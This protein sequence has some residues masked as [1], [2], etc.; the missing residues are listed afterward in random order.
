MDGED[1]EGESVSLVSLSSVL[2]IEPACHPVASTTM[3]VNLPTGVKKFTIEDVY[4]Y[5]EYP[6][7]DNRWRE[8]AFLFRDGSILWESMAFST[9]AA[10]GSQFVVDGLIHPTGALHLPGRVNGEYPRGID[11]FVEELKKRAEVVH[12]YTANPWG[13]SIS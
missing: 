13:I 8:R 6:G 1:R 12:I 7:V 4:R 2:K 3:Q 9:Y 10:D 11:A 5:Q